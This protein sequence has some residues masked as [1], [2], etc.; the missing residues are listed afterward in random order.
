MMNKVLL[1]IN[2]FFLFSNVYSQSFKEKI[3]LVYSFK[4]A[5]LTDKQLESKYKQLDMFWQELNSDTSKNFPLLRRELLKT[6]YSSYFYFDMCSYLEMHSKS[7]SDRQVIESALKNIVW[8]DISTWEL[9]DKMREFSL[10]KIDVSSVALQLLQQEK[11]KLIDP[12]SKEIF[13]QGKLLA[14]LLL[15]LKNAIYLDKLT[16]NFEK[17]SPESQRSI[18][19][20]L[21][22]T[23]TNYGIEKLEIISKSAKD[24]DVRSYA[25]RL[26]KRFQPTEVE[27]KETV[28]LSASDKSKL[29]IS[30]FN[31][32]NLEW[33]LTSWDRLIMI[34]KLMHYNAIRLSN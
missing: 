22:I 28:S 15:P 4:I 8:T 3:E 6:N 30:Q 1:L 16:S 12:D 14:Y 11:V 33:D 27:L 29:L 7:S 32:A 34:S 10:N 9:V 17:Y 20:L 18:I 23:N 19:T 24:V 25:I 13:N 21:W 26:I 31:K 5:D 2:L